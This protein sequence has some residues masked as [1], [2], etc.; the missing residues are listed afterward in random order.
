MVVLVLR[1]EDVDTTTPPLPNA[2]FASVKVENS[3]IKVQLRGV[4]KACVSR[5]RP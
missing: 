2:A 5:T 1:V 4:I 3:R